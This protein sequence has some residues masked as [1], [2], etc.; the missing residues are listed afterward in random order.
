MQQSKHHC[1]AL[2]FEDE[3]DKLALEVHFDVKC[4]DMLVENRPS[5]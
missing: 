1:V 3:Y 5:F 4:L 2:Y